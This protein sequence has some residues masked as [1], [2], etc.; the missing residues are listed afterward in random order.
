MKKEDINKKEL[1]NVISLGKKILNLMYIVFIVCIILGIVILCRELKVIPFILD[2][3]GV[4][5]SFFIGFIFAW[6]FR[7]LVKKMNKKLPNAISSLII[8]LTVIIFI[9]IFVYIFIP[10][11]YN[12]VNELAGK[13]PS[14]VDGAS[15][16]V[17]DIFDRIDIEQFDISSVAEKTIDSIN[18]SI[19]NITKALPNSIINIILSIFSGIGT[20]VMGLIIG[21]YMLMDYENIGKYFKKILP[22]RYRDELVSLFGKISLEARKCVNG[23]LLVSFVVFLCDSI[24]F[25]IVGLDAPILFGLFCGITDLIPYIGPYIGGAVAVIVGFTQSTFV[26]VAILIICVIVQLLESYVLQPVVMSKAS[27]LHPVIIILGLLVFGHFFGIL[28]MVLATPC[29]AMLNVLLIF[30]IKKINNKRYN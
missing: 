16:K 28:G 13:I 10:L 3:L 27:N 11:L 19:T 7:P 23:T 26:G 25:A 21:L 24:G 2:I 9:I 20:F 1:N 15:N 14:I 4:L 8:F 17:E 22:K 12:E 30:I 18:I 29:I 6:I 5:T